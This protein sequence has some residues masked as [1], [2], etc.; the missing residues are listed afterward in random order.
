[1][2]GALSVDDSNLFGVK[3]RCNDRNENENLG[4]YASNG[5]WEVCALHLHLGWRAG[6]TSCTRN[7]TGRGLVFW[8]VHDSLYGQIASNLMASKVRTRAANEGA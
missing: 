4:S 8:A 7:R 3:A 5:E 1:M 6:Q 2:D